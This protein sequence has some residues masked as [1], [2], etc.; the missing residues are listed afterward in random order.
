MSG[1]ALTARLSEHATIT[2]SES[3]FTTRLALWVTMTI[4][5]LLAAS[6]K[7]GTRSACTELGSLCPNPDTPVGLYQC[8]SKGLETAIPLDPAEPLPIWIQD[9]GEIVGIAAVQARFRTQPA[10]SEVR[11]VEPE[12]PFIGLP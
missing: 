1:K 2:W 9:F 5:R 10:R 7:N 4:C 6:L 8:L 3:V 12:L 11:F